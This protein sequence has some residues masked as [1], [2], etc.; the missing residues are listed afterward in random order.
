MTREA[1]D[2]LLAS[3]ERQE[4]RS[5]VWGHVDG[6]VSEA[7]L[8][9]LAGAVSPG[10]PPDES[11]A[12][13]V[14]RGLIFEVGWDKDGLRYRSR[15]AETT[16]LLLRLRQIT[17][18]NTW[19]VAPQLVADYRVDA[20]PRLYAPRVVAVDEAVAVLRDARRWDPFREGLLRKACAASGLLLSHFQVA[21]AQAVHDWHEGHQGIVITAGTGSGKTLAYYLPVMIESA[22]LVRPGD[23][24]VKS[25]SIYPRVELLKDQ[26][27]EAVR[28]ASG[29]GFKPET[30]GATFG[31]ERSTAGPRGA[32]TPW[33]RTSAGRA[34]GRAPAAGDGARS[35]GARPRAATGTWSG[36]TPTG[37]GTARCSPAPPA[38]GRSARTV[39]SR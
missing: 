16:R 4:L 37:A 9:L 6:S 35:S 11:V 13:L 20:R 14:A 10:R 32:Q 24:W 26:F 23:F 12:D 28:M 39:N 3:V 19:D 36:L 2:A 34:P 5:L 18:W 38:A 15:F 33:T 31:S 21:T 27:S 29:P 8:L 7:E 1:T 22:A 17:R 25:V 30:G